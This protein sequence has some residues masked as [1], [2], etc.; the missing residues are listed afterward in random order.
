[1]SARYPF[2][3]LADSP[4]GIK[5]ESELTG[6][7][8]PDYQTNNDVRK[9]FVYQRVPHVTLK[10][11]ANNPDIKE[12]MTREQIDAAIAKH[13][14]Q[15]LL[16]DKPYEDKSKLRVAGPFTVESLSP[17][18][19]LS[20]DEEAPASEKAGDT[21]AD[22]QFVPLVIENLRAAGVQNTK[23]NERLKFD[24]L[25]EHSGTWIQ[26]A[27][28]FK[29]ANDKTVRV[30]VSVGS[31]YAAVGPKHIHEA[32][33]EAVQ[34]IG[35]DILVICGYAFDPMVGEE[36]K[37]Y[38][39]LVVLPTKMNEDLKMAKDLK[40][41]AN[42]NLFM[43]FGEPDLSITKLDDNQLQVEVKGI[44]IYDPNTGEIRSD[45][46]DEIACWF[47][48]TDYN[49]ESFF[50]RHAYFLGADDPYGK[51]KKALKAEIDED[52]WAS[53]YSAV[54]RPSKTPASGKIAV[55][56]INHYGDEI[57]KVYNI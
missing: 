33:K 32:A 37:N 43:V 28:S 35:F 3:L 14:D 7:A 22:D 18:R 48:D 45:T 24:D 19:M 9:G 11:I 16:Y 34:G 4:E 6:I 36:A 25:H 41:S 50:V 17:H 13:A 46:P 23:K 15:E 47:I 2:Y 52:A 39:D 29:D 56:V 57:L 54:S 8:P 53:L 30:A 26:A 42:A 5:K 55:K 38:G 10:S 49:G 31:Q 21:D 51:L 1:M 20:T 27:G 40:K 12:G 44:D